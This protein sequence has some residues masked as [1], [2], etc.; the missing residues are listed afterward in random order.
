MGPAFGVDPGGGG[1]GVCVSSCCLFIVCCGLVFHS[2]LG[3][4][5]CV[6]IWFGVLPLVF[7]VVVPFCVH[8]VCFMVFGRVLFCLVVGVV[9]VVLWCGGVFW[10]FQILYVVLVS[11]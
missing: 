1:I 4:G 9:L 10:W 3:S 2:I 11:S 7:F 5:F 6:V 8:T